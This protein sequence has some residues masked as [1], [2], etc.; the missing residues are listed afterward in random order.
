MKLRCPI[1][2]GDKRSPFSGRTAWLYLCIGTQMLLVWQAGQAEEIRIRNAGRVP[3]FFSL[4]ERADAA[5]GD[6]L[7]IEPNTEQCL[8]VLRPQQIS[9]LTDRVHFD[10]LKPGQ[11]YQIVDARRGK[12]S[13][14]VQAQRPELP[15]QAH[16]DRSE[17]AVRPAVATDES[18][19][20]QAAPAIASTTS[21]AREKGQPPARL[22]DGESLGP[23]RLPPN[24]VR[25]PETQP[26]TTPSTTQPPAPQP[27]VQQP[28]VQQPSAGRPFSTQPPMTQSPR[29]F[30]KPSTRESAGLAVPREELESTLFPRPAPTTATPQSSLQSSPLDKVLAPS[31][32]AAQ[33]QDKHAEPAEV[34]T[35]QVRVLVDDTYRQV[36]R[37]WRE[38]VPR[39]VAGASGYFERQFR[40]R[41]VLAVIVPWEYK[42]LVDA[43]ADQWR[44]LLKQ[45]TEG[46]DLVVAFAG[47]GDHFRLQPETLY[48]GQLGRA[49][50]FGQHILIA[51]QRDIHENRAKTTL[52]HELGHVFGAFHVADPQSIMT[53]QYADLPGEAIVA[54]RLPFGE[55]GASMIALTRDFHFP[56]GVESLAPETR[57]AIQAAYR[58]HGM[59]HEQTSAD[60]ITEGYRYL[61]ERAESRAHQ[62]QRKAQQA[63][64]D[65]LGE[66]R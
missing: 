30:E 19:E 22:A 28:P 55:P 43:P 7:T 62:W 47:Y 40:I 15:E 58:Q 16:A 57:Q 41:L 39:I 2:G 37:D 14:W 11:R 34:R 51:D 35:V 32:T 1:T 45:S 53:P 33:P 48:T 17:P 31:L 44:H 60:P 29:L 21:P 3:F 26:S 25:P 13:L 20:N 18:G 64:N 23:N 5:W 50:F 42:A 27:P 36:V 65:F 10:W 52:I 38:R 8:Q 9:Y 24:A 63:R 4:R 59:A 56:S 12:L 6:S 46:V 66:P 49:A 54:G 61:Q